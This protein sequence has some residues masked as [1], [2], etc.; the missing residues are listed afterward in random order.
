MLISPSLTKHQGELQKS[1]H[2]NPVNSCRNQRQ[3]KQVAEKSWIIMLLRLYYK[4]G[5]GFKFLLHGWST[6]PPLTYPP[7]KYGLNKA[8]L[9]ETNG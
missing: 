4:L 5:G 2:E 6:Y 9:R 8:L 1:L 7:Q 3:Q